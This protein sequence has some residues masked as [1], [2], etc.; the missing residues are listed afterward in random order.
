MNRRSLFGLCAALPVSIFA[1]KVAA[2][3]YAGMDLTG[4]FKTSV[5][6]VVRDS[7]PFIHWPSVKRIWVNGKEVWKPMRGSTE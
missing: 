2:K 3:T 7:K 5:T 4:V 6:Y 1:P